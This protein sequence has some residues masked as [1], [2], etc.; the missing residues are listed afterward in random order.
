MSGVTN[1]QYS[2]VHER[3][4]QFRFS[5]IGQLLAAPPAKGELRAEITKLAIQEWRHPITGDPVSFSFSTIERWYR[6]A[7]KER[8]DPVGVLRRQPRANAGQQLSMSDALR[9]AVFAQYAEHKS[10][11]IQLHYDNLRALAEKEPILRPVPSYSTVRRFFKAHGLE[12]RKRLTSMQTAGAQLAEARL[13]NREVRSYEAEYVGSLFHWDGHEGSRKILTS[14]GEWQTP[15]LICVCDDRSRLG[16]HMQWYLGEERAEIVVHCLSQAFQKRGLPRLGMSDRGSAMLAA[17]VVQGLN[18][19]GIM[20]QTTLPYSAYQ[21]AKIETMW[22]QVEGRL[23]AM[24]EDVQDLSLEFLN[25]TTL[26]WLEHEYNRQGHS[27]TGEAPLTRF[28]A[29]PDVLRPSPDS[30][31]LRLAFT[32]TDRRIQRKSDGTIVIE[33]HRFEIPNRYRHFRQIEVRYASWDLASVHL[34]DERTGQAL[35][36]LFPQDKVQNSTGLRRSLEPIVPKPV[37]AVG[38]V[39]GIPP[40]LAKLLAE[41]AASGLPPAYL[42]KTDDADGD[43]E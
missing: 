5:V 18:R 31:A 33:G 8:V 43:Q 29:G 20:H 41:Q 37:S 19:L 12:K 32:K 16:C 42:P 23:L 1:K 6:R 38:P 10:W 9:Q 14:R 3:W 7:L 40:L 17:E 36:R 35:C 34:V 30:A 13:F 22:G 28:L 24:L 2:R 11:S 39:Q 27:E 15:I 26:A 25:V 4:A 21:N